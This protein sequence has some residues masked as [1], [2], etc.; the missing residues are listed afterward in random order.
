MRFKGKKIEGR[1]V[2]PI[3][4]MRAMGEDIV[5]LAEAVMSY[6]A[7]DNLVPIPEAPDIRRPGGI[8]EKN[9]QDPAFEKRLQV[10]AETKTNWTVLESLKKT[11]DLEWETIDPKKSETWGNW[12]KELYDSGFAEVEILRIVQGVARANSLDD[13]MLEEA[14]QNFILAQAALAEKSSSQKDEQAST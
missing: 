12:K 2:E 4:I 10:Y 8:K 1:N 3:I 5:F 13:G 11:A 9:L 7:F 6:D 14:R